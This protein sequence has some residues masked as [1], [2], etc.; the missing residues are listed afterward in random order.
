LF[1]NVLGATL[2][3]YDEEVKLPAGTLP[4][5][6]YSVNLSNGKTVNLTVVYRDDQEY[7]VEG[8]HLRLG[9]IVKQEAIDA[10]KVI[11]FPDHSK[12][13]TNRIRIDK[14]TKTGDVVWYEG[15]GLRNNNGPW[16]NLGID[17]TIIP[18]KPPP[19]K[20][21]FA[22]MVIVVIIGYLYFTQGG[23]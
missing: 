9:L 18:R 8:N 11:E 19:N 21:R 23:V 16:G 22:I 14:D 10:G 5:S 1:T 15:M 17:V 20:I 2:K 7:R 4:G 12:L 6:G 3:L 13:F